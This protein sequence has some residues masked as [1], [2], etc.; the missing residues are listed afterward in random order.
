MFY[1]QDGKVYNLQTDYSTDELEVRDGYV[2]FKE[3]IQDNSGNIV[4]ILNYGEDWYC[5]RNEGNES[6]EEFYLIEI[7]VKHTSALYTWTYAKYDK[8]GKYLGEVY[9]SVPT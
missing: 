3:P 7:G 6:S 2:Y 5:A 1:G 4:E 9:R 8:E